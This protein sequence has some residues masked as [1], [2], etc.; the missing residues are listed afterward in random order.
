MNINRLNKLETTLK[1]IDS[2]E[3]IDSIQKVVSKIF[4]Y[5]NRLYFLAREGVWHNNKSARKIVKYY[6]YEATLPEK[7]AA[8]SKIRE[9]FKKLSIKDLDISLIGREL[10]GT[11]YKR[12]KKECPSTRMLFHIHA[13]EFGKNSELE[14]LSPTQAL[15][16]LEAFLKKKGLYG[17]SE[18]LLKEIHEAKRPQWP[19]FIGSW[20]IEEAFKTKKP[21][22]MPG[23]W[24]GRPYGHAMYYEVIPTSDSLATVRFFNLG[25]GSNNHNESF[26]DKVKAAC[27][28]DLIGVKKETLLKQSTHRILKELMTVQNVQIAPYKEEDIYQGLVNLFEPQSFVEGTLQAEELKTR[29]RSGVCAW[30]SLMAFMSTKLGKEEYK[31]FICDIKMQSLADYVS[32]TTQ[33]SPL[34]WRLLHK[35]HRKLCRRMEKAFS[36]QIIGEKYLVRVNDK[37]KKIGAEIAKR[38][39]AAL[40]PKWPDYVIKVIKSC[41]TFLTS[42]FHSTIFS[43]KTPLCKQVNGEGGRVKAQPNTFITEQLKQLEFKGDLEPVL[44][45]CEKGMKNTEYHALHVGLVHF[46]SRMT[47][48]VNSGE[49]EKLLVSLS[50]LVKTFHTTCYLVPEAELTHAERFYT[51][52]KL[53]YYQLKLA[54]IIKPGHTFPPLE[55]PPDKTRF[56]YRYLNA[57]QQQEWDKMAAE[58]VTT[59]SEYADDYTL[60]KDLFTLFPEIAAKVENGFLPQWLSRFLFRKLDLREI[61]NS[62]YVRDDLPEWFK[63]LR[64]SQHYFQSLFLSLKIKQGDFSLAYYL[65]PYKTIQHS[66]NGL[67]ESQYS[68]YLSLGNKSF[69]PLPLFRKTMTYMEGVLDQMTGEKEKKILSSPIYELPKNLPEESVRELGRIACDENT[70]IAEAFTYFFKYPEKL[71]EADSQVYFQLLF[72]PVPLFRELQIKGFGEKLDRF[73]KDTIETFLVR[74]LIQPVVFLLR[75][76]RLFSES[77]PNPAWFQGSLE[78]LQQL[79]KRNLTPEEKSAVYEEIIAHLGKKETLSEAEVKDLL[80]GTVH[81]TQVPL[82]PQWSCPQAANEARNAIPTHAKTLFD[83][84][85][86]D[87]KPNNELLNA[88][89][90]E[91]YQTGGREWQMVQ[92]K[93]EF[94]SFTTEGFTYYPLNGQLITHLPHPLPLDIRQNRTFARLF[95]GVEK[96]ILR[97]GNIWEFQHKGRET[98]VYL[99]GLKQLSIEQKREDGWYSFEF[100]HSFI[101]KSTY[102]LGSAYLTFYYD[103]WRKVNNPTKLLLT[104][105]KGMVAYQATMVGK[106]LIS[107]QNLSTKAY[108]RTPQDDLARIEEPLFIHAWSDQRTELPRFGLTFSG[109]KCDQIEGFSLCEKQYL[110]YLGAYRHYLLLENGLGEKKVVMP[111]QFFKS[112]MKKEV[113]EPRFDIDRLWGEKTQN[114]LVFDVKEGALVNKSKGDNLYLAFVLA[115]VQEYESSMS[116]LR[117]YGESVL[118]YTEE[119]EESLRAILNLEN[120]TGDRE[121]NGFGLRLFAGD[122]LCRNKGEAPELGQQFQGYLEHKAQ[123]TVWRLSEEEEARFRIWNP[124]QAERPSVYHQRESVPQINHLL[125]PRAFIGKLSSLITRMGDRILNNVTALYQT[126]KRGSPQQKEDLRAGLTFLR[127]QSEHSDYAA[128]LEC[129]LEKPEIYPEYH[130]YY[131]KYQYSH[132]KTAWWEQVKKLAAQQIKPSP[133]YSPKPQVIA[134]LPKAPKPPLP[135]PPVVD[136]KFHLEPLPPFEGDWFEKKKV[137]DPSGEALVQWLELETNSEPLYQKEIERLKE[138]FQSKEATFQYILKPGAE[139]KINEALKPRKRMESKEEILALARRLPKDA[140][141]K[142]QIEGQIEGKTYEPVTF[143]ELLLFFAKKDTAALFH[144]NPLLKADEINAIFQKIG[145]YLIEATH[146]Q[147]RLRGLKDPAKLLEKR[148]YDPNLHPAYLVFEHYADILLRQTQIDNLKMFLEGKDPN[149]ILE[150]IMGSGKSKVL[151]PLLT[152]LRADGDTLSMILV[153]KA[154]FESIGKDTQEIVQGAFFKSVKKL[155]IDRNKAMTY[156]D[157]FLLYD[158]LLTIRSKGHGLIMTSK[159][160]Q[161]LILK[162]IEKKKNGSSEKEMQLMRAILSLLGSRGFPIIDEADTVANVMHEVC[163]SLGERKNP[164]PDEIEVISILYEIINNKLKG[165]LTEAEFEKEK[166]QIALEFLNKM[167]TVELNSKEKQERVRQFFQ[168]LK[169]GPQAVYYLCHDKEGQTYFDQQTEEIQ[170]IL[171]LAG[172]V[173]SKYLPHTLTQNYNERYGIDDVNTVPIA[174]PFAAANTPNYGSEFANPFITMGYTFQSYLIEGISRDVIKKELEG[175]QSQVLKAIEGGAKLEEIPAMKLFLELKGDLEMPLFKYSEE[176]LTLLQTHVNSTLLKKLFFIGKVILPKMALYTHKLSCNPFHLFGFFFKLLGFTGTL[177]NSKSMHR[178]ITPK[179]EKGTD[180]KTLKL[181]WQHSFDQVTLIGNGPP[182]EML[183]ELPPFDLISD[184]GGYFKEGGNQHIAT[185]IGQVHK[186]PV[187]FYHK[188]A[189]VELKGEKITPL[190]ESATK[191]DQRKTFLDQSHT[192]GADV[193]QKEEAVG[194]VTIGRKMLLRDLLQSAW[195][196]RGLDQKQ[197][198]KFVISRDVE[199]IM[200]QVLNKPDGPLHFDAIFRFCLMNQVK[201]QGRDNFKALI[202]ELKSLSEMLLFQ[203]VIDPKFTPAE[204]DA[205]FEKLEKEWVIELN[206]PPRKLFGKILTEE[207]SP[208]VI[209]DE[210]QKA[211][212][213]LEEI[214]K[215]LPFLEAKGITLAD[216]KKQVAS[217]GKRLEGCLMSKVLVPIR[218]IDDDQTIEMEQNTQK[219]A[220][221]EEQQAVEKPQISLSTTEHKK[222]HEIS[223]LKAFDERQEGSIAYCPLKTYLKTEGELAPFQEAFAGICLTENVF[224][225]NSKEDNRLFLGYG[226]GRR[227]RNKTLNPKGGPPTGN[228]KL[229]GPFR[230]PIH[231]VKVESDDKVI[232]LSQQDAIDLRLNYGKGAYENLYHLAHGF[233]DERPISPA[234]QEKIVKI[235]FLN[236]ESAYTTA[237]LPILEKWLKSCGIEQMQRLFEKQIIAGSP[238]KTTAFARSILR[239]LFQKRT[240]SV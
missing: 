8:D 27:T 83:A 51:L 92:N 136:L 23:G 31:R 99:D 20:A 207:E 158:D 64:D 208:Q 19:Y 139:E 150:M 204:I 213:K 96:G 201:Q 36:Q 148:V 69:N 176:Q 205:A 85:V 29:Q 91:L 143:D 88:L 79:L 75:M 152:L 102:F 231:Y 169:G 174:I 129:V 142:A 80:A 98:F 190:S 50:K 233:Y 212:A 166:S 130:A 55:I 163:F 181:L 227:F 46:V 177:W 144:R 159:S 165:S 147:H 93:E 121:G 3:K 54:K 86:K 100:R 39:D 18:D 116:L 183:S 115:A 217:I 14:G 105:E 124:L 106:I 160:M 117:K 137:E 67:Y 193:K 103:H 226:Y 118:P 44:A 189:Q 168:N 97:R 149:P 109:K 84:L 119:E 232:L 10:Q 206:Q 194:I 138:D 13:D 230:T 167:K 22:L 172:E 41:E 234:L 104:D 49:P 238:L 74:N 157:L 95:P 30:R 186:Q 89:T 223:D 126:A 70:L 179:P 73:L 235:K 225:R 162:Y 199:K 111:R 151:L 175:I 134:P 60:K 173:I 62:I 28:F 34:E 63:G 200:R 33:L 12:E 240:L 178:K 236:G 187:V 110:P 219:E 47:I 123:A 59:S 87:G 42:L 56:F 2:D 128:I 131:E 113:L 216:A 218:D 239:K 182:E 135:T 1:C 237:E 153:P 7:N 108:L 192:I 9:I 26:D 68:A 81:L 132:E 66:I 140:V 24:A 32:A 82:P 58:A 76:R 78:K 57:H 122:L 16:Y 120:V 77:S 6:L 209:L 228:P 170:D 197:R 4:I 127:H 72:K 224:Q 210:C 171:A 222:M 185:L 221:L 211:K 61:D 133:A 114:F 195:R 17:A 214:F 188:G 191:I 37:L 202:Q 25:A 112:L 53:H 125:P 15:N 21:L 215:A 198:V 38:K 101:E 48:D 43:F 45:L 156:N 180:A 90:E 203:V 184:A 164:N 155:H 141:E 154:L 65:S 196:L 220:E 52:F 40:E 146:E 94:P 107:L 5:L 145:N 71:I 11:G 161:C 35:S 229:F